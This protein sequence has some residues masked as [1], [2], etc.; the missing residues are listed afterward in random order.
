M[1]AKESEESAHEVK[2]GNKRR[3]EIGNVKI[4]TTTVKNNNNTNNNKKRN[5]NNTMELSRAEKKTKWATKQDNANKHEYI[6][7]EE[8]DREA[9]ILDS[10]GPHGSVSLGKGRI[11]PVRRLVTRSTKLD[12]K[13]K[14]EQ[15]HNQV[16][17]VWELFTAPTSVGGARITTACQNRHLYTMEPV[18]KPDGT[19]GITKEWIE[20]EMRQT[21]RMGKVR[22][23]WI[24]LPCTAW[25]RLQFMNMKNDEKRKE[26]EAER[27]HI[28]TEHII[29]LLSELDVFVASGGVALFEHPKDSAFFNETAVVK[30]LDAW[31]G[32]KVTLDMCEFGAPTQ[33]PTT[34]AMSC[35]SSH[36]LAA[37]LSTYRVG[38]GLANRKTKDKL[39]QALGP[40]AAA[41]AIYPEAFAKAVANGLREY[42]RQ[43]RT[44]A[45]TKLARQEAVRRTNNVNKSTILDTGAQST[46][47]P[48]HSV[49]ILS[50]TQHQFITEGMGEEK[51]TSKFNVAN[52][53]A[54]AVDSNGVE[55]ILIFNSVGVTQESG[56][57]LEADLIDPFQVMNAG[58]SWRHILDLDGP[59]QLELKTGH[60]FL[61][62]AIEGDLRLEYRAPRPGDWKRL[63]KPLIIT[64]RE[65]DFWRRDQFFAR[66]GISEER[67]GNRLHKSPRTKVSYVKSQ[68]LPPGI[69]HGN[70]SSATMDSRHTARSISPVA[71]DR[72]RD[73]LSDSS[74]LSC[75]PSGRQWDNGPREVMKPTRKDRVYTPGLPPGSGAECAKMQD[76][77]T[78]RLTPPVA[79]VNKR[80]PPGDSSS[81]CCTPRDPPGD[82]CSPCCT[83]SK[84]LSNTPTS[85]TPVA[86]VNKWD[87]L[88]DSCSP[89]CTPSAQRDPLGD[90]SSPCCTPST[91]NGGGKL[92]DPPGDSSSPCCTPM[93]RTLIENF[94]VTSHLLDPAV[95]R[96]AAEGTKPNLEGTF[97]INLR[98]VL[99]RELPSRDTTSPID[100]AEYLQWDTL[101][102]AEQLDELDSV[103]HGDILDREH[104]DYHIFD[105][106]VDDLTDEDDDS[107]DEDD[108]QASERIPLRAIVISTDTTPTKVPR[109]DKWGNDRER[110]AQGR[111]R[112]RSECFVNITPKQ[113]EL[114][115]ERSTV[116]A[117]RPSFERGGYIDR[118]SF[119]PL[120]H[121]RVA[122]TFT[123][124]P[125]EIRQSRS[126]HRYILLMRY[127]KSNLLV[128][129]G[130][131]S[132][133][134]QAM[135]SAILKVWREHGVPTAMRTDSAASFGSKQTG[136]TEIERLANSY[137]VAQSF[138]EPNKQY[139]NP[140]ERSVGHIRNMVN[141]ARDIAIKGGS[142]IPDDE[143]EDL[144]M[145]M[146]KL[147][148]HIVYSEGY[149]R[150]AIE[151]HTGDTA[152][153]SHLNSFYYGEKV[154][155][156]R[157]EK[158][159]ANCSG[160][161]PGHFIGTA[162]NIGNFMCVSVR[163]T[164]EWGGI[165]YN[166]S[167]VRSVAAPSGETAKGS[168]NEPPPDE[169]W[170]SCIDK[171][172][173]FDELTDED[174][175]NIK[176]ACR[177]A[178]EQSNRYEIRDTEQSGTD[179]EDDETENNND[180]VDYEEEY[181]YEKFVR[182]WGVNK[183]ED[184]RFEIAWR[185]NDKH[186]KRWKNTKNN[187]MF[188]GNGLA[189]QAENNEAL[190]TDLADVILK[191]YPNLSKSATKWAGRWQTKM[192]KRS[193]K[194][195][196]RNA[197]EGGNED[198]KIKLKRA[199]TK[200]ANAKGS[201]G[202]DTKVP[203]RKT[204]NRSTGEWKFGV[205]VPRSLREALR[206]DKEY[207]E[208]ER[209]QRGTYRRTIGKRRWRNSTGKEM[210]KFLTKNIGT[211]EHEALD[212]RNDRTK[213]APKGYQIVRC[214]W[215]FD[216][217]SD[218]TLKA[219]WVAGGNGVDSRGVPSSM[220]VISTMGVRIM[221]TQAAADGQQVLSGDLGNAYLHAT[222][223]EK[224]CCKL[225]EEWGEHAGKWA[226][227]RKAI[228]GLVSSAYEF[229]RYVAHAMWEMGWMQVE[230]D[231]DIWIR[232][233]EKDGLYDRVGFYVDDVIITGKRP[234]D[235]VTEMEGHFQFKFSGAPDRY[236][237]SDVRNDDIGTYFAS[238]SYIS[239]CID[240]IAT[241]EGEIMLKNEEREWMSKRKVN[242]PDE[243]EGEREREWRMK[244]KE[245][246]L[247]KMHTKDAPM[248]GGYQPENL[249]GEEDELLS[250][251]GRRNYQSLIGK[252]QWI[253][254]LGR[255]DIG[256]AVS[257]LS[258][259]N[260]APKMGHLKGVMV[261]FGF[262]RKYIDN[263]LYISPDKIT[264][265]GES[266]GKGKEKLM[267]ERYPYAEEERSEREP[268]PLSAE[269][270]TTIF[271]DASHASEYQRRSVTGIIAYYGSTPI[272]WV[273][274]RQK[275][276]A[277]STYES[278]FLALKAAIDEARGL[279]YLIRGMGIEV[280][281]ETKILGDNQGVLKSAGN[282]DA[283]LNKK[284]IGIAYHRCREAIA[285]GICSL[286]Y[287]AS[288]ENVSD[289]MTK[290]LG[291]LELGKLVAKSKVKGRREWPTSEPSG[292]C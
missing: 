211:N 93:T 19:S 35:N 191:R 237:G 50:E 33:K 270:G 20:T 146:V 36:P 257:T 122:S 220:T 72:G 244:C 121:R 74:S 7:N 76:K 99:K 71:P 262:L 69:L 23:I 195:Q 139:Q 65:E 113:M 141:I 215:V 255:Y 251:E 212:I 98:R 292:E 68:G 279:R 91:Q 283:G 150:P 234:E 239:E 47:F 173:L 78:G 144:I 288:K 168:A 123:A 273:S 85:T 266:Y 153:I 34:I 83:P 143:E 245:K 175:E 125:I 129:V 167:Q 227:I 160:W 43:D 253:G 109:K 265:I 46:L 95:L 104:H 137:G 5:N 263:R 179:D 134:S 197:K 28:R 243:L 119:T 130:L 80:D 278:E 290:A 165:I 206:H 225:G 236:L 55:K 231:K 246:G 61:L 107:S 228:Y 238:E 254:Q 79:A 166:S 58:H 192:H 66:T 106:D 64:N 184:V 70:H 15:I 169:Y 3:G 100:E 101:T 274:K 89:C 132:I 210:F 264:G 208:D 57:D 186:G 157:P 183:G 111:R 209:T 242:H 284:H 161:I 200:Q 14:R 27:A 21:I 51:G 116:L 32:H 258:Q 140:I 259:F 45:E 18:G 177:Q 13:R 198:D 48:R 110:N 247:S 174:R 62:R 194:E 152:D 233:N 275:V 240:E 39:Q 158:R 96:E 207:D 252:L 180:D 190:G 17:A 118:R 196:D 133:T 8:I 112:L 156:W 188:K 84:A 103:S 117:N 53:G 280:T 181:E 213:G 276:I 256:Y 185:G 226:V 114:T 41:S 31:G 75:T 52:V 1:R 260:S 224:V 176:N 216:V 145:H 267:K 24:S 272:F 11:V 248:G 102:P 82:S 269:C 59:P 232:K 90:S 163:T 162:D 136:L 124:D 214:F 135:A 44:V 170:K 291:G 42:L 38:N 63:G 189:H 155:V 97:T 282:Y 131:A 203:V 25:S 221:F 10:E 235:I 67:F 29:P 159:G 182:A 187:Y 54:V 56:H 105:T 26:I 218:G 229:H 40:L 219:R 87:P 30:A 277:G 92:R 261:V 201:T 49:Q 12:E 289:M 142:S 222:T 77:S 6:S 9:R 154:E 164:K 138:S 4:E 249:E 171:E 81:P 108:N 127:R 199:K 285:C 22:V 281:G 241:V 149:G 193:I 271:T 120:Q 204:I 148:N 205:R 88:G 86:S 178:E 94:D 268:V 126:G 286:Y 202:G 73:P 128:A 115:R 147:H 223:N 250:G 37:C 287:V 172:D 151:K 2:D 217:K 16:G 60:C 230:A